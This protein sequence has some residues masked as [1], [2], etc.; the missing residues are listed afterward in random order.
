MQFINSNAARIQPG[1]DKSRLGK[2]T[3]T[4]LREFQ[5]SWNVSYYE[6]ENFCIKAQIFKKLMSTQNKF[7]R[8]SC[9]C[10]STLFHRKAWLGKLSKQLRLQRNYCTARSHMYS[11]VMCSNVYC[12]Q[13]QNYF[14]PYVA[15]RVDG[16]AKLEMRSLWHKFALLMHSVLYRSL[17]GKF[18]KVAYKWSG[19]ALSLFTT[20]AEE[21]SSKHLSFS[22]K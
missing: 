17:S 2:C 6:L 20:A 11:A 9:I 16:I 15:C 14:V 4:K 19:S 18:H 10:T 7:Q 21:R 22:W 3:N 13:I 8:G 1:Y 5:Y 12:N